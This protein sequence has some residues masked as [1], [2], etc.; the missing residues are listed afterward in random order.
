MAQNKV[1]KSLE[2]TFKDKLE[3]QHNRL[4]KAADNKKTIDENFYKAK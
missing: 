1:Q 4:K 2:S 3:E